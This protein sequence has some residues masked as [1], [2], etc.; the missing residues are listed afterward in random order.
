[1]PFLPSSCENNHA[2]NV[3]NLN[4]YDDKTFFKILAQGFQAGF[5]MLEIIHECDMQWLVIMLD[6]VSEMEKENSKQDNKNG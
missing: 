4:D 3:I 6:T 2:P 1:M 5:P